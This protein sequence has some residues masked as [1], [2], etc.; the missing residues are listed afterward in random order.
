MATEESRGNFYKACED[1][2]N[3]PLECQAEHVAEFLTT[4][5]GPSQIKK[6]PALQRGF[7]SLQR[8]TQ[9]EVKNREKQLDLPASLFRESQ[10]CQISSEK[11]S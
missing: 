11:L 10:V 2:Y 1:F 4:L 9:N 5:I 3:L 7:A 8:I 6:I